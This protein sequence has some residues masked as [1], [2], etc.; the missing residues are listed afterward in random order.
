MLKKEIAEILTASKNTGWI[1]EP[2]A[3]RLLSF[4][5]VKIPQYCWATRLEEALNFAEAIGYPVAAKVVSPKILHKSDAGGVVV[6]IKDRDQLTHTFE[7][8]STMIGFSG[9]HV[10]KMASGI[11]LIVGAKIDHQFGPVMLLGMGGTGVEIY[12]DTTIRMAPL[13][14][15]DAQCMI[16]GL[17]AGS[18]LQGYRSA[19]PIHMEELIHLMVTVSSLVMDL[20]DEIESMDLN[21]V[22]CTSKTCVIADARIM[23]K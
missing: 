12:Q 5:G 7:K 14:P 1:L 2:E 15:Y 22:M 6:G 20:Q 11:E 3:K 18:L 8:F 19:A 23:L 10:E 17:K 21:P 9:M 16:N 4:S 13:K